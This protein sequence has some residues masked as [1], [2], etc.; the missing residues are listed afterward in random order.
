M[1][2]LRLTRLLPIGLLVA[3]CSS[4]TAPETLAFQRLSPTASSFEIH[5]AIAERERLVIRDAGAWVA[6]WTRMHASGSPEPP[7]PAVDFSTE[8]IVAVGMGARHTGGFQ[9]TMPSAKVEAGVLVIDVVSQSPGASCFVTQAVTHPVDLARV[10]R[11]AD[12]RF[13]ERDTVFNCG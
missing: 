2:R 7:R 11:F 10:Q 4:P 3:A 5:S 13:E 1:R 12:V 6:F 9:I 8:M